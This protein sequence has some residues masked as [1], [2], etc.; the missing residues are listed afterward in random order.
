[1]RVREVQ[2]VEDAA[3]GDL[4]AGFDERLGVG[5]GGEVVAVDVAG[6]EG[7][8][9][10]GLVG[11]G[12]EDDRLD[13]GG[14]AEV[15]VVAGEDDLLR[16]VVPVLELVGPG[17]GE[18][19]DGL[20]VLGQRRVGG[21]DR[22]VGDGVD[23]GRADDRERFEGERAG[24]AGGVLAQADGR[25]EAVSGAALVDRLGLDAHGRVVLGEAAEHRRV[26]VREVRGLV[27]A[28]EVGPAV[29]VLAHGGAVEGLAVVE[30]DAFTQVEGPLGAGLVLLVGLGETGDGV[31]AVGVEERVEDLAV[32]A[33]GL[34]VGGED[35][36]EAGRVAGGAEDE[37]LGL[38]HGRVGG[39]FAVGALRTREVEVLGG[40]GVAAAVAVGSASGEQAQCHGGAG[41]CGEGAPDWG[42]WRAHRLSHPSSLG[43]RR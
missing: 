43:I 27:A 30:G 34:T 32:D 38:V 11:D 35:R 10:G 17:A 13:L 33:E 14:F 41:R 5:R 42:R 16:A 4:V 24:E 15:V 6:F 37:R 3:D 25:C 23:R 19:A 2:Q 28:L 26:V 1:L 31:G 20:G 29:E 22:G 7:L 39:R 9:A 18:G 36:V 8:A 21:G 12:L 40:V